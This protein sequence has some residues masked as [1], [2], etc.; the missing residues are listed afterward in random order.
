MTS[1]KVDARNSDH[2]QSNFSDE[3]DI[4]DETSISDQLKMA[5]LTK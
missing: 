4:N 1:K 5:I 2:S 3:I